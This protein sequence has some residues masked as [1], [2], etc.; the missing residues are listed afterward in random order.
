MDTRSKLSVVR[1][2]TVPAIEPGFPVVNPGD[3]VAR[4]V[5]LLRPAQPISFS[6][7]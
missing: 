4:V 5:H 6:K 2:E 7:G 3:L 1:G